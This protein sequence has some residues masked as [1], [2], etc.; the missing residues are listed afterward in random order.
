MS[1]APP[2]PLQPTYHSP[3][4]PPP[5]PQQYVI[6]LTE[7]PS[8]PAGDFVLPP[9]HTPDP[10]LRRPPS[11]HAHRR[12]PRRRPLTLSSD[13]IDLSEEDDRRATRPARQ[14]GSPEIQF[15]SSRARSRSVS[16]D[17]RQSTLRP[18]LRYNQPQDPD[19]P[20]PWAPPQLPGIP[21]LGIGALL[22]RARDQ[23]VGWEVFNRNGDIQIPNFMDVQ[24]VGFDWDY[25]N[26]QPPQVPRLP[27]YDAP[28]S[29]R[30]GFKRSPGEDDVLV[31]P[32]CD[33][34][35][36]TGDGEVKRQVW[37]VKACG[38]V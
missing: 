27:T 10:L 29:P 38:H 19:E 24:T 32:N 5:P 4:P 37:V 33:D 30:A 6:D 28:K 25:P 20:A 3:V 23:L 7:E 13:F 34:E 1:Q 12:S 9:E 2:P 21:D 14:S 35:L 11:G 8:R 22:G 15:L 16:I 17:D 26:R 36:G 31:C 18:P